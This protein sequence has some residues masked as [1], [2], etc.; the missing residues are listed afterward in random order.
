MD[1]SS[2]PVT[3]QIL[4]LV[5]IVS[6]IYLAFLTA[7]RVSV[8]LIEGTLTGMGQFADFV[9]SAVASGV[10]KVAVLSIALVYLSLLWCLKPIKTGFEKLSGWTAAKLDDEPKPEAWNGLVAEAT[11]TE[12]AR[13]ILG[14]PKQFSRADFDAQRRKL[15]RIAHPDV[16]G[17]DYLAQKINEA[18]GEIIR[19]KGWRK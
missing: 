12:D 17:S 6:G 2:L 11:P 4:C 16:G 15:L 13:N 5:L 18:C 3:L 7:L 1:W 19:A 10:K 9:S 8:V 14:L